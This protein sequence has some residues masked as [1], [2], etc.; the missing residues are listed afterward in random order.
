MGQSLSQNRRSEVRRVEG[1][2]PGPDLL[3][4]SEVNWNSHLSSSPLSSSAL[5][6]GGCSRRA[7]ASRTTGS[8]AS[9]SQSLAAATLKSST[10]EFIKLADQKIGNVHKEA[11]IDL[12]RRQQELGSLVGADQGHADPG[13]RQAEG[14]REEP[15][16][17][18]RQHADHAEPGRPD[19]AATAAGNPEPGSRAALARR[20]RPVGRSA[21]AQGRRAGRHD[22]ALRLRRA[23]APSSPTRAGCGPT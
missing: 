12:T 5:P 13:R 19:A 7:R 22:G 3:L 21:A 9:R 10:D 8:C 15:R 18:Q 17:R 11:A 2:A 14:S 23:A 4:T 6:P 1:M 20:P 16:R